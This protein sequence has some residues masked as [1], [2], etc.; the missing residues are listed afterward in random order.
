MIKHEVDIC[1]VGAGIA[2]SVLA[3]LLAKYK[4]LSILILDHQGQRIINGKVSERVVAINLRNIQ[5]LADL[6]INSNILH[7]NTGTFNEIN[8]WQNMQSS[9]LCFAAHNLGYPYLGKIVFNDHLQAVLHAKFIKNRIIC[10]WQQRIVDMKRCYLTNKIAIQTEDHNINCKLLIGADGAQSFVRKNFNFTH[11]IIDY[12]QEAIV[13]TIELS[14]KH[15][16]RAYQQFKSNEIL[17]FLPLANAKQC[18]IVWSMN[19]HRAQ[20]ILSQNNLTNLLQDAFAHKFG[21]IAVL[22]SPK[23]FKLLQHSVHNYVMPHVALVGDAAHTIHPLAGQGLNMGMQDVLDLNNIIGKAL[24][25][26]QDF[27]TLK[28]LNQYQNSRLSRNIFLQNTVFY[29]HKYYTQLIKKDKNYYKF[30]ENFLTKSNF[31]RNKIIQYACGF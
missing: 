3:L 20:Q 10:L 5:L 24:D 14:H 2:G 11:K 29:L 23:S 26:K 8:I 25:N 18:S 12:A 9:N 19:S 22:S 31:L 27:Y 16:N 21:K 4:N 15:Q 30:A 1:I 7:S 17:A 28:V 13:A 6:G